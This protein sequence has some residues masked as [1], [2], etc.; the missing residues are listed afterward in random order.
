[1]TKHKLV[2]TL[3]ITCNQQQAN[4]IYGP[5][6]LESRQSLSFD[7]KNFW[8]PLC[9]D[10]AKFTS[11]KR[12]TIYLPDKLLLPMKDF[13]LFDH[14]GRIIELSQDNEVAKPSEMT[15]EG[16][17]IYRRMYSP[18]WDNAGV[19]TLENE[20]IRA[21][22]RKALGAGEIQL[23]APTPEEFSALEARVIVLESRN[24]TV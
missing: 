18:F 19:A 3:T 23:N 1:M 15:C 7:G 12:V 10:V 5:G 24:F 9:L 21:I 11:D 16:K 20:S 22:A 6:G 4:A 17:W 8:F 14:K 2:N 13:G